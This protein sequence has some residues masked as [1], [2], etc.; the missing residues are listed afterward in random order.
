MNLLIRVDGSDEIGT[1][2]VMRT[3]SIA[4]ELIDRGHRVV[5]CSCLLLETLSERILN[6]GCEIAKLDGL[7]AGE[8]D[9]TQ[10]LDVAEEYN[11]DTIILDGYTFGSNYLSALCEKY[12]LIFIDDEI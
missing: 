5:F 2:H 9:L 12:Q 3:F 10:T 6:I 4:E 7:I 8:G 11:I 1:G